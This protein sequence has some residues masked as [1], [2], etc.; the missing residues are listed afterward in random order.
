MIGVKN[1]MIEHAVNL[2]ALRS[3]L[4]ALRNINPQIV[5]GNNGCGD[6]SE[7]HQSDDVLFCYL[8]LRAAGICQFHAICGRKEHIEEKHKDNGLNREECDIFGESRP[9]KETV[10]FA[11]DYPVVPYHDSR[12]EQQIAEDRYGKSSEHDPCG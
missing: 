1:T 7:D 6:Q 5:R 8:K 12:V 11:K 10:G 4:S 2:C 9:G 3:R